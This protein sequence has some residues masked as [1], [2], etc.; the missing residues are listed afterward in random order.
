MNGNEAHKALKTLLTA[1]EE[2]ES[3]LSTLGLKACALHQL[4]ILSSL[5]MFN[6]PQ[7]PFLSMALRVKYR[8]DREEELSM[9]TDS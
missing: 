7:T 9:L 1:I 8:K 5:M 2:E 4:T 3:N 6:T